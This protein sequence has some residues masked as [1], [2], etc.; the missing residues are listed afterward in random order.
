MAIHLG[1]SEKQTIFSNEAVE[2]RHECGK[3]RRKKT[4]RGSCPYEVVFR[5]LTKSLASDHR[6]IWLFFSFLTSWLKTS[7]VRSEKQSCFYAKRK[8]DRDDSQTILRVANAAALIQSSEPD[9]IQRRRRTWRG[10]STV[11]Y[12]S[13]QQQKSCLYV[14][15]ACE[16]NIQVADVSQCR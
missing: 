11:L 2:K 5:R 6:E 7:G 3:R 13:R 1:R 12:W 16:K 15:C 4:R 10:T 8:A 9:Y 14:A